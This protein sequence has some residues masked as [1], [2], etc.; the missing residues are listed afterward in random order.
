MD[1]FKNT[2]RLSLWTAA[3]AAAAAFSTLAQA[4]DTL[5]SDAHQLTVRYSDLDVNTVAGASVLY[6]RLQGAAHFVCGDEGRSLIEQRQWDGCVRDALTE[7]VTA[8]HSP[9]LSAIEAG[10]TGAM[11]T[12]L[13]RR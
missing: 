9:T 8:V 3:L 13:L 11:Q 10:R 6:R 12:A 4:Q 1:T 5:G 7:A 2:R